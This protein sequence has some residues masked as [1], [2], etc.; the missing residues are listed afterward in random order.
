MATAS[1]DTAETILAQLGGKHF[2]AM[3]GANSFAGGADSLSFRY[4]RGGVRIVLTPDDL[5]AMTVY[6]R[7]PFPECI[8]KIAEHDGLYAD[9]LA[10]AFE[11]ATGL[12][13]SL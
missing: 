9:Q 8:R 12:R 1:M 11:S 13:V 5:Y 7:V 4:P 2:I 10:S 6:K 3:T